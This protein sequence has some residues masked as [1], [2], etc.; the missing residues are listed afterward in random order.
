MR[1]SKFTYI[2][3]IILIGLFACNQ[4]KYVPDGEYLLKKYEVKQTGDKL[5]KEDL[6]SIVRQKPN[7]RRF[8][9]KWK[10][11]AYNSVDS[12]K[13]ADKRLCKNLKIRAENNKRKYKELR[14]N[15]IRLQKALD[16]GKTYYTYKTVILKDSIEPRRFLREWYKYKIGSPPVIFDSI[17]YTKTIEQLGAYLK[18]KG[19][20]YGSAGGFV[21]YNKNKKC[22]VTYFVKTGE[23]YYIDSVF[24]VCKNKEVEESYKEFLR[25]QNDVPLIGQPFDTDLLDAYRGKVAR[26][27]RDSSFYGF[28]A[29]HISY[30][31]D[32]SMSTMKA[33]IKIVFGDRAIRSAE[34]RD[35]L[36][37][38]PH[39][40]TFIKDVY[41]HISDSTKYEGN[42]KSDLRKL[43]IPLYNG[44][45][46]NTIDTNIYNR[47]EMKHSDL[48]DSSRIAIFLF[49]GEPIVKPSIL[50]MQNNLEK[51]NQY[52]EKYAENSYSSLLRMGLFQAIKTDLIELPDTN[53]LEVHYYLAPS[54]KQSYSFQPKATNSNGY[55]GV[56][57]S[58]NYTNRNLFRGA[59]RL[60]LSLSGGFESQPPV[61]E[62]TV[63]GTKI[64]TA[65]RSF[66]T[67]EF[68]PSV[69]LQLPGLFPIRISRISKK[70]RPETVIS[71]AYNYQ[72]RPDFIRGTFQM[73]Y[74]WKFIISK[75]S[76]FEIGLPAASVVKFVNI[77][78]TD[79]FTSKLESIGDLFL[80]N[81]YNNQF[82]WQDWRFRY[83]YNIKEKPNRKGNAQLYFS[84]VFDPAGNLLSAFSKFQ[85]TLENGQSALQGVA[86]AQFARLDNQV[87]FSKPLGR[88]RS[89]NTKFQIG[90]GLPYGNTTTSLPYDYSFFAGGANDNRGWPARGLGPGAYKY[91]LDTNRSSTQ[92]GDFR[93]GASTEFRFAFN[94]F[95]KG[96]FFLD[97]GNV[98]T[99]LK[100]DNRPGGQ[101]SK[102]WWNEIAVAAGFGLR[103]D[104]EYFIVRLDVGFPIRNTSLPVGERWIFQGNKP[105]FEAEA[106]AIFGTDW[107]DQN[108]VPIQG[109]YMPKIHFGIGYPF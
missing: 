41:F 8:G 14:I 31:A 45:F 66:N 57:A 97:A 78:K 34:N 109:L 33:K 23:R 65:A 96:A 47:V 59:E 105:Q 4:T 21:E 51:G 25:I 63:N 40:K 77:H 19:F 72:K 84:T 107:K 44:P 13:V 11:M 3:P 26:F 67:L 5:D 85:D 2:L 70:R 68:G 9:F 20:F 88:E 76:L 42:L 49:N 18:S 43:N 54:K 103:M 10:L 50:E 6:N 37:N 24:Y 73:N 1:K 89:I 79:E 71:L 48:I 36:I 27:M 102:S 52:K 74:M 104:L 55:L 100:D 7:Y 95:F 86:Y 22:D 75:T 99:L 93:L 98:W 87:I 69:K 30:V 39:V 29:N 32:T 62:K 94:S 90:G 53:L 15:T 91:Y 17:S 12:T 16:K 35:S 38:V 82:V 81:A 101:L 61:F 46:M 60:T 64:Q 28:S 92:I 80:L 106:A 56:S 83:E 108:P 58:I